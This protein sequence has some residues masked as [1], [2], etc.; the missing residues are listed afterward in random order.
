MIKL[1][2]KSDEVLKLAEGD[3]H[4]FM[5]KYIDGVEGPF[6]HLIDD[7]IGGSPEANDYVEERTGWYNW[8]GSFT[9]D[10]DAHILG[11][12]L[13]YLQDNVCISLAYQY[14]HD[15]GYRRYVSK[16]Q[17]FQEH[18]KEFMSFLNEQEAKQKATI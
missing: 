10:F 16:E 7:S 17:R 9:S 18:F 11:E 12:H 15:I 5:D 8:E 4:E 6:S 13:V 3:Y 2:N 14:Y 1:D